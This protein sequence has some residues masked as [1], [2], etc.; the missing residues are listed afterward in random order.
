MVTKC[1]VKTTGER[2]FT[3]AHISEIW[4][5]AGWIH[6]V[7]SCVRHNVTEA[8][9]CSRGRKQRAES[10][11][12]STSFQGMTL[13]THFLPLVK[14]S[15]L[16]QIVPPFQDQVF[17]TKSSRL[18]RQPIDA[19]ISTLQHKSPDPMRLEQ[20]LEGAHLCEDHKSPCYWGSHC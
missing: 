16:L 4:V 19:P 2:L 13:V 14:L 17:T 3:L 5:K 20:W 15:S 12:G 1:L 8:G 7:G 6:R 10:N 11:Q 9:M 18:G